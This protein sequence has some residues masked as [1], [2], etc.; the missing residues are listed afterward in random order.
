MTVQK[1]QKVRLRRDAPAITHHKYIT[2]H[3]GIE[4]TCEGDTVSKIPAV[5]VE[6]EHRR[7]R[8]GVLGHREMVSMGMWVHET[9]RWAAAEGACR[10]GK[11]TCSNEGD[12]G[13]ER[14]GYMGWRV[15]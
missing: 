4:D 8:R 12:R 15:Q 7:A 13:T 3:L 2:P 10:S 14:E 6:H 9:V 11:G 1:V 5:P